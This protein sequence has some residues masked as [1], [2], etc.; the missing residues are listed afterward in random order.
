MCVRH[1]PVTSFRVYHSME[2]S[3][4]QNYQN[5]PSYRSY[6]MSVLFFFNAASHQTQSGGPSGRVQLQHI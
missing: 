1:E 3:R 5:F 2:K 6:G 4:F